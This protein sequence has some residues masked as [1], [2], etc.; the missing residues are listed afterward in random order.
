MSIRSLRHP[1]VFSVAESIAKYGDDDDGEEVKEE[2][3]EEEEDDAASKSFY[4]LLPLLR[5]DVLN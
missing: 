2:K 3:N 1:T 4:I 5:T